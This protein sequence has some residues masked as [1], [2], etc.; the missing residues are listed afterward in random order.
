MDS[1]KYSTFDVRFQKRGKNVGVVLEVQLPV[2]AGVEP[3][4]CLEMAWTDVQAAVLAEP[5]VQG[6]T[7]SPTSV[8]DSRLGVQ[9]GL[10]T[11]GATLTFTPKA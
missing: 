1:T 10:V 9:G 2:P 8:A 7:M 6:F 4:K 11:I 5:T 3:V